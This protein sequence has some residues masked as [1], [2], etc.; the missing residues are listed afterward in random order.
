LYRLILL[1]IY[2]I[3]NIFI[4]I[5]IV[6]HMQQDNYTD[7]KNKYYNFKEFI[8]NMTINVYIIATKAK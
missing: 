3:I 6:S 8:L 2:K 5:Y 1:L 7:K 4:K